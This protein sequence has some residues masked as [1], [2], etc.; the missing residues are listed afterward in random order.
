MQDIKK[1]DKCFNVGTKRF[2]GNKSLLCLNHFL[3]QREDIMN[4][5]S[6]M[7]QVSFYHCNQ[8][9]QLQKIM[10]CFANHYFTSQ[11]EHLGCKECFFLSCT[12]LQSKKLWILICQTRNTMKKRQRLVARPFSSINLNLGQNQWNNY[13]VWL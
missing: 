13:C 9:S 3:R 8:S 4:D 11:S 12:A 5:K 7:F 1:F 2:L 10:P 6:Q